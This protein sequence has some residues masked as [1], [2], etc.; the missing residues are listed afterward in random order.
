MV[1]AL[2]FSNEEESLRLMKLGAAVNDLEE[3]SEA[4]TEFCRLA[5]KEVI[6]FI[7]EVDKNSNNQL[8]LSFIGMLRNKYLYR[9]S[10]RDFT[11]KSVV[12]VGLYDV[13]S[14][15]LKLRSDEEAKYNSPWN[16]AVN[17][18]VDM[19]FSVSEI[20]SIIQEYAID[21]K[22]DMNTEEISSEIYFFTS[23]YPYLVSKVCQIIDEK[24]NCETKKAWTVDNVR[25][26]IKMLN[27]EVST[28]FES[29]IKNLENN[30]E[31]YDITSR[32]LI[33]G[34]LVICNALEPYYKYRIN[35]WYI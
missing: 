16:I 14:L 2:K 19:S 33:D 21:N 8:F 23:G 13:K 10:G 7:D 3:T 32:I 18:D 4:I 20:C 22:L 6:L 25:Q 30:K 28:L 26:A 17:F 11:F 31:L 1:K 12:L 29:I 24:I 15:K 27:D 35:L 9:E 5:S 34:E